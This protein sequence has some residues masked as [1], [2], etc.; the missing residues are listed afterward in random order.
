VDDEGL[1]AHWPI[2]WASK[3]LSVYCS[4][5]VVS[6]IVG[7]RGFWSESEAKKVAELGICWD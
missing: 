4:V 2:N 1:L 7:R 3:R 5:G 6:V